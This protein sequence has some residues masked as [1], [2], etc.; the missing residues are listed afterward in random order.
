[1]SRAKYWCFTLN[2]PTPQEKEDLLKVPQL[3]NVEYLV[4]GHETGAEGTPHLQGYVIWK[5]ACRFTTVKSRL[6]S[7]RYHLEVARGSPAQN[8][9]YCTKDGQYE[10]FGELPSVTQGKRSDLDTFFDWASDEGARLGRPPTT[11]EAARAHPTIITKYRNAMA[12]VRLRFESE[13][14]QLGQ[15]RDWQSEL[16]DYLDDEPDD[17]SIRFVVD[18]QGNKGK[19]W[20]VRWYLSKNY[21]VT[22]FLSVGKRDD[23][24]HSIKETTRVFLFDVPRGQM[25]FFQQS[26]LEQI[27]NRLIFS[28]K[29]SSMTKRLL[30]NPHVI[31]FCNEHPERT[32]TDDRYDILNI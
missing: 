10:E 1:M 5:A 6:G 15:L 2:N 23:V 19:S 17:R 29:Y 32:M 22:Q 27:K 13:P 12:V 3:P 4:F 16:N 24:A 20:F 18:E 26:V 8:R 21:D 30:C 11:P 14:L 25:Q 9:D 28:P 7:A 31:V